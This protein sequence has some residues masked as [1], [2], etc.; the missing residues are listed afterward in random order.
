METT[1]PQLAHRLA[2]RQVT[3]ARIES[4]NG[5]RGFARAVQRHL[6]EKLHCY[7][8]QIR[9]FAQ[10]QNKQA[11]ILTAA[12]WV[13]THIYYP[14]DWRIRWPDY[15]AAMSTYQ[16]TGKNPHDDAPDAT[17]GIAETMQHLQEGLSWGGS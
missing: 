16:C 10:T 4:N 12:P 3:Q 11:R 8:V 13:M 7:R 17:T 2:D 5:G 9:W 1:E 15:A 14:A 6:E